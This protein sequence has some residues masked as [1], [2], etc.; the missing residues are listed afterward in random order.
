MAKLTKW[1][2]VPDH[3]TNDGENY[4]NHPK[5][6]LER[7]L[8]KL[9]GQGIVS[10]KFVRGMQTAI[11]AV[12]ENVTTLMEFTTKGRPIRTDSRL[13][14]FEALPT[15]TRFRECTGNRDC[16]RNDTTHAYLFYG[17][18]R[19][20]LAE[21]IDKRVKSSKYIQGY[22]NGLAGDL[23]FVN[24]C[25]R[26]YLEYDCHF[27]GYREVLFPVFSEDRVLGVFFVGELILEAK[28]EFIIERQEKLLND[29]PK[30]FDDYC[31]E[32]PEWSPATI[33]EKIQRENCELMKIPD[34]VLDKKDYKAIVT[35]ASDEL[36]DFE[37]ILDDQLKYQ[38]A[39]HVRVK[40]Q[41]R[42][43]AFQRELPKELLF[44]EEKR[45]RAPSWSEEKLKLLWRNLEHQLDLMLKDLA[46]QYCVVFGI[47]EMSGE[48]FSAEKPLKLDVVARAGEVPKELEKSL[49]SL[50][51]DLS[52]L[53][54]DARTRYT[55]S[56]A[57]PELFDGLEGTDS[58]IC[59]ETS[60]VRMV[61]VPL[62]PSGSLV[63]LVGYYNHN[64]PSALWN[65]PDEY[66]DTA[67]RSFYTIVAS[68][69]SSLIALTAQANTESAL[70]IFGHEAGQQSA[71][72]DGLRTTYISKVEKLRALTNEKAE[73]LDTDFGAY[74]KQLLYLSKNARM[75]IE[76][77]KPKKNLYL[78][79]KELLFKWKDI[80][81]PEADALSLSLRIEHKV[82]PR[83]HS[84]PPVFIDLALFEQL[85]YNLLNNAVKYCYRGTVIH[86]DCRKLDLEPMSPHVLTVTNYGKQLTDGSRVYELYE[87]DEDEGREGL[88]VGLY[89]VRR[90]AE[91]HG[92]KVEHSSELVSSF[93]VPLI[94]PY[95]N[96]DFEGK[97]LSLT[98]QLTGEMA[99]LGDSGDKMKI[100]AHDGRGARRYAYPSRLELVNT[101]KKK[102]YQ[103]IFTVTIPARRTGE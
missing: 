46:T 42:T 68:T 2:F 97:D 64:L 33:Q 60:R 88:G 91:A 62:L 50:H 103:T 16:M 5:H 58:L 7:G 38:R 1:P 36:R 84:R 39:E 86:L 92:G 57:L 95:L 79:Y 8:G 15:C 10:N 82:G 87:R 31:L 55:T 100:V 53:T 14:R 85:L 51:F 6:T 67:L 43:V 76:V 45:L 101:I 30:R 90:I 47:R 75:A 54:P 72:L 34:N 25:P 21:E 18:N 70:R 98:G 35:R 69:L 19:R 61:P 102:T 52:K 59:K 44:P 77:P 99:R 80:Y 89:I 22:R 9:T 27:L 56:S 4:A 32:H 40:L 96:T 71:G 65:A 23:E 81:R 48:M 29:S 17:L 49:D 78:A 11:C 28:E 66:L 83:D 13:A 24:E 93:N 41:E 20:N 74:M 73:D 37:K 3:I 63:V 12:L 94:E 26:S